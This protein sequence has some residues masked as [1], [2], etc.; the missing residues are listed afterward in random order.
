MAPWGNDLTAVR[1]D[2]SHPWGTVFNHTNGGTSI[3]VMTVA[4]NGDKVEVIGTNWC[5]VVPFFHGS[6]CGGD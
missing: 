4:T 5:P 1:G 2:M 6:H 3:G